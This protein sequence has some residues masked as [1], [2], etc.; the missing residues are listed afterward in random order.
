MK[1]ISTFRLALWAGL[2]VEALAC[3]SIVFYL[4]YGSTVR[5]SSGFA[6]ELYHFAFMFQLPGMWLA[7]RC[8][9]FAILFVPFMVLTATML[10][11]ILFWMSISI[12]RR[13]HGRNTSA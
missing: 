10:F 5:S 2:F 4:G 12:W 9:P 7:S 6:A 11:A 13:F 1:N 3:C 8:I